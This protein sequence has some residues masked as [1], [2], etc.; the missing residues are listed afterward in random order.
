MDLEDENLKMCSLFAILRK[1]YSVY[2]AW[3]EATV[4]AASALPEEAPFLGLKPDEPVLVV[5]GITFNESFEIVESVR[6]IYPS[7]GLALYIGRQ[8]IGNL[9]E[10]IEGYQYD[11]ILM[12]K[13]KLVLAVDI[14]GT[15]IAVAVI[16]TDGQDFTNALLFRHYRKV[17]ESGIDQIIQLLD[18]LIAQTGS[19]SE[20]IDRD[21]HRHPCST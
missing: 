5:R 19:N 7:R 13:M 21:R 2:P 8:R 4:E 12:R 11:F 9:T 17:P 15:K 14:G 3:T 20:Q 16:S 1:K 10:G 18:D 6:T